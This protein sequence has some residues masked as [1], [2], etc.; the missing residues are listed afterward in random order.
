MVRGPKRPPTLILWPAGSASSS[1]TQHVPLAWAG[2]HTRG[3]GPVELSAR[4]HNIPRR[5]NKVRKGKQCFSCPWPD[6]V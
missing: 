4:L 1:G 3:E 2:R 6:T 5:V